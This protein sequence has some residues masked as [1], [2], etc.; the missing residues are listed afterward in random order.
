MIEHP[1]WRGF[2][3]GLNDWRTW[4]LAVVFTIGVSLCADAQT[5]PVLR[6]ESTLRIYIG[7]STADTRIYMWTTVSTSPN[8]ATAGPPFDLVGEELSTFVVSSGQ[9]IAIPGVRVV[10]DDDPC[11]FDPVRA[12]RDTG[13]VDVPIPQK[14]IWIDGQWIIDKWLRVI[15]YM[16]AVP[17]CPTAGCGAV[18]VVGRV[19]LHEILPM[20][21]TVRRR[22]IGTP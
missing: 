17:G 7:P 14:R 13:W 6:R 9:P 20:P 3:E 16:S 8:A 21:T 22:A 5:G 12:C 15:V 11:R 10:A 4:L 2:R 19:G 18:L 1:F